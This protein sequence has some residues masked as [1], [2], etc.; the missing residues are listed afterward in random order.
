[1]R[2]A[3]I[4]PQLGTGRLT[5]LIVANDATGQPIRR[6]ILLLNGGGLVFPRQTTTDDQGRFVIPMLPPGRYTLTA[7]RSGFV[8]DLYGNTRP[9]VG[10]GTSINL[11][12][13][14]RVDITMRMTRA[15]AITGTVT[16]ATTAP[17][18][19]IV[20]QA[21]EFGR[22]GGERTL[23]AARTGGVSPVGGS[24]GMVDDR[25]VYR[26]YGLAPGNY[27]I[28]TQQFSTTA[29][30]MRVMTPA[31]VDWAAQQFRG[32]PAGALI[33]PPPQP[34]PVGYAPVYFPG[35]TDP[36]AATVVTVAAGEERTGVDFSLPLVPVARLEGTV[37]GPGGQPPLNTQVTITASGG[38]TA[39]RP[40][41]TSARPSPDGKFAATGVA[42][43]RYTVIARGMMAGGAPA[44]APA[45]GRGA[46]PG[47]PMWGSLDVEVDGR[48]LTDLVIAL[49][50]GV[51]VSGRV[52]FEGPPPS[53][54]SGIR[55]MLMP[56][57]TLGGLAPQ[58]TAPLSADN[59][60]AVPG[61]APGTYRFGVSAYG[62]GG[63]SSWMPKSAM[64]DGREL[65]DE[66]IEIRAG[67]A[68]SGIVVT[69]T[70][71]PA[72]VSGTL[73]D[74]AGKPASE[75]FILVFPTDRRFWTLGSRRVLQARPDNLGAFTLWSLPAGEYYVCAVTDLDP[76]EMYDSSLLEPLIGASTKV[77]LADGEQKIHNM[78]LVGRLAR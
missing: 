30:E 26:L 11:T 36:L 64:L 69:M 16:S 17:L 73:V 75:Y 6:A 14:Q 54:P 58:P 49:Q 5:G 8:R 66:P 29:S 57:Q 2:D 41:S 4:T 23:V 48:D 63:A 20:V 72:R 1:M 27:V 35:T 18:S 59:S 68:V 32:A 76:A 3:V 34:R 22:V 28:T 13:G 24:G 60:F 12:E 46:P 45:G 52:A 78:K 50:P 77:V 33:S 42:P 61:V 39:V 67:Q 47:P 56:T 37:L 71:R 19:S 31:E 53:V 65:L 21:M 51:T 62:P 25:G 43:G 15:A 44:A 70:D 38:V 10:A 40:T 9:G 55:A 7:W 74:G